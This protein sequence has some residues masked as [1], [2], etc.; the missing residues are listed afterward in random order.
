MNDNNQKTSCNLYNQKL[1]WSAA[2]QMFG[3][4]INISKFSKNIFV[5]FFT[6]DYDTFFHFTS[7]T[8]N[9]H[10]KHNVQW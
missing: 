9:I 2:P 6:F 8:K 1:L 10:V 5:Y 7:V 4:N 3:S